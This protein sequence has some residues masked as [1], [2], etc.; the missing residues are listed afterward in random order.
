MR[1]KKKNIL[2]ESLLIDTI[3]EFTAQEKKLLSVLHNKFGMGSGKIEKSWNFDKWKAAAYLIEHFETPYD[4]AHNL[5]ST[6]YWNG[7]KLFKEYE[8][9]WKKNNRSDLLMNFAFR[10]ILDEYIESNKN[11]ED[12]FNLP[13]PVE[14]N[15]KTQNE[16]EVLPGIKESDPNAR[17]MAQ[18]EESIKEV[19]EIKLSVSPMVWS[20]YNGVMLYIQP[21][22]DNIIEPKGVRSAEWSTMR[23]MGLTASIR[24]DYYKDEDEKSQ[25]YIKGRCEYKFGHEY[26]DEGIIW[27]EDIK[28]PEVLSKE[29]IIEFI[30]MLLE[31]LRSTINGMT[32]IYGKGVKEN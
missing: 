8:T 13:T 25:N 28:L 9:L 26:K 31:K 22:E 20:T 19:S 27:S 15:V 2:L 1:I 7:D 32:F 5:A 10:D 18:Y 14:Y 21:N 24:L 11:E 29:K 30:D 3:G 17:T 6:Y 4:I 16:N 23:N 12:N